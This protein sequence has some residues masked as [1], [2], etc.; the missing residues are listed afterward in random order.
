MKNLDQ[1]EELEKEI[2]EL[3]SKLDPN[4]N[5]HSEEEHQALWDLINKQTSLVSLILDKPW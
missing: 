2:D 4:A 1:I 5:R 3:R